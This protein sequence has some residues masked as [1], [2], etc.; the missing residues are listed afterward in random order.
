MTSRAFR[1]RRRERGSVLILVVIAAT[2]LIGIA[3]LALDA[4]RVGYMKARLQSVADAMALAAA[5]RLDETGSTASACEAARASLI[6]NAQGFKEL[7]ESLPSPVSCSDIDL[8]YS[9]TIPFDP[10]QPGVARYVRVF[11]D[12]I[13]TGASLAQALGFTT[14]EVA[15]SAVAGPSAPLAEVCS[16]LPI[17]VC[18]EAEKPNYGFVPGRVYLLKGKENIGDGTQF[19]DF[20]FLSMSGSGASVLRRDFAGGFASCVPVMGGVSYPIKSGQNVGPVSEGVNTRFNEHKSGLSPEEY[21]PDVLW[22]GTGQP[23]DKPITADKDGTLR[24]GSKVIVWGTDVAVPNRTDYLNR[25]ASGPYDSP[26]LPAPNGGAL[27]RREVAV[28]IA[29]CGNINGNEIELRGAG[30]FFLLQKM[31]SGGK[32][33][34]LIGEFLSDCAAIG[35]PGPDPGSGGPY[36]IQ[37]FRDQSSSDS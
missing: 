34:Q 14:L 6:A 13:E 23:P 16:V 26:L 12:D 15:A 4:S 8:Q 29:N 19:G 9:S 32:E 3:G 10:T 27:L 20:H 24:Q 18:G 36:V 7:A 11:L 35:T 30:C 28:P 22:K 17:A 33:S 5:K 31:G 37:L 25:L 2:A 21:P 1:S